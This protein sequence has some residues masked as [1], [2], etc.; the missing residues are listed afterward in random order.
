MDSVKNGWPAMVAHLHLLHMANSLVIESP[1]FRAMLNARTLPH[2][3]AAR[4]ES[5]RVL[6][7]I[8]ATFSDVTKAVAECDDLDRVVIGDN[9]CGHRPEESGQKRQKKRRIPNAR[10]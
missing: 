2:E 1:A 7:R 5:A 9:R 3:T 4:R 10:R 8:T 6:A